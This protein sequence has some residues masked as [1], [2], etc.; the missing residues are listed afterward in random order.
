MY[1]RWAAGLLRRPKTIGAKLLKNRFYPS[2][3]PHWLV[4][5]TWITLYVVMAI[6]A[7]RVWTRSTSNAHSKAMLAFAIQLTLNAPWSVLFVGSKLPGMAAIDIYA[8][9]IAIIASLIIFWRSDCFTGWLMCPHP[10]WV[11]FTSYLNISF[12]MLN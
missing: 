2:L 11:T 7:S 3:P 6:V 9:W 5:P 8:L 4:D 12:L 10:L 1:L